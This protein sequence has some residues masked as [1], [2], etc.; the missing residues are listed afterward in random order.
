M[1]RKEMSPELITEHLESTLSI[2][3]EAIFADYVKSMGVDRWII[4]SDY[5]LG[6]S[7]RPNDTFAF[8]II[9][10]G[11]HYES[12][13]SAIRAAAIKDLKDIKDVRKPMLN[14][15]ADSRLFTFC[16]IVA[17]DR[18]VTRNVEFFREMIDASITAM[19]HW[20]DAAEHEALI[21]RFRAL[22]RKAESK[23]FNIRLADNILLASTFAA[24]LAF[25]ISKYSRPE[26]VGWFS[27]RDSIVTAH[28]KIAFDLFNV[29][30]TALCQKKLDGWRG[31]QV[32]LGTQAPDDQ[33]LWYDHLVRIPDHFAGAISAWDIAQGNLP[34]DP[35]KYLQIVQEVVA[36]KEQ[37]QLIKL[38]FGADAG[39]SGVSASRIVVSS[40]A[41]LQGASEVRQ[42]ELR[43][44]KA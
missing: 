31:P 29:N 12:L 4:V 14:L 32:G 33:T 21:G 37:V 27:D 15:M 39:P 5:V 17:P 38:L 40:N 30:F 36:D 7:D 44:L 11:I 35:Q 24:F 42:I 3:A 10:G 6:T 28:N 22:R 16:F 43:G 9:P 23:S 41:K 26:I 8:S 1:K 19:G 2:H 25:M 34:A 13:D 18:V 20:H